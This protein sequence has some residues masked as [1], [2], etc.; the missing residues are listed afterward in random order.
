MKQQPQQQQQLQ[1]KLRTITAH[2]HTQKTMFLIGV[3]GY[4]CCALGFSTNT[5]KQEIATSRYCVYC[6][7]DCIK[8][9]HKAGHHQL[10]TNNKHTGA[11]GFRRDATISL[12]LL[13]RR[14]PG[15]HDCA[16]TALLHAPP[17]TSA[18]CEQTLFVHFLI[19]NYKLFI[20]AGLLSGRVW[21]IA[22]WTR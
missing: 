4:Q 8:H 2:G 13:I 9:E 21:A 11:L 1:H 17:A 12:L 22:H 15:A 18:K 14:S 20:S 6:V 5:H 3:A 19:A 16:R 7:C 10:L